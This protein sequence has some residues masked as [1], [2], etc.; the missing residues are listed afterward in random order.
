MVAIITSLLFGFYASQFYFQSLKAADFVAEA[1]DDESKEYV[2][3]VALA[4]N[5]FYEQ[6][7]RYPVSINEMAANIGTEFVAPIALGASSRI[8]YARATNLVS[9]GLRF[10]RAVVFYQ[11][12]Q[13]GQDYEPDT[14]TWLDANN[15]CGGAFAT[16]PEW[17][18][19]DSAV[20]YR[21]ET[22]SLAQDSQIVIR[23]TMNYTLFKLLSRYIVTNTLPRSTDGDATRTVQASTTLNAGNTFEL[24]NL[25]KR[26]GTSVI[27]AN[28]AG[29]QGQFVFED[30]QFDCADLYSPKS[31]NPVSYTYNSQR[32][33]ILSVDSG[34]ITAGGASVQVAQEL[35][36]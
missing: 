18:G 8:R 27:G 2:K 12:E 10:E 13:S 20:W 31:G 7:N 9:N 34:V 22:R 21:T 16:S 25:V 4:V 3:R 15:L 14:N 32:N 28:S 36:F 24:R 23:K 6:N 5:V 1:R 26:I 33:I 19:P 35:V 17:C 11:N 30:V 29:C